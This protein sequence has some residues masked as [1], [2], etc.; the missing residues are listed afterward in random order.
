MLLL[1]VPSSNS[2]YCLD[3]GAYVAGRVFG[4]HKLSRLSGAAGE[5]SPNKTLEG[6][7]GGIL[8][9]CAVSLLGAHI[10]NW[11]HWK[12]TGLVYGL[13]LSVV[14]MVGDLT[15][16]LMKRNAGVKDSGRLLPG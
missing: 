9:G 11:P 7:C 16:S 14:G 6:A 15:A 5:A 10:M 3:I 1:S 2:L 12:V 8:S 4:H 13:M